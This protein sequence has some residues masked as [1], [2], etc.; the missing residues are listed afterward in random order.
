MNVRTR[1]LVLAALMAL[2]AIGLVMALTQCEGQPAPATGTPT[3]QPGAPSPT[4]TS[5]AA[6]TAPPNST[7]Q[8]ATAPP[9]PIPEDDAPMVEVPAGEFIMG[10]AGEEIPR[11][12]SMRCFG[13]HCG[14]TDYVRDEW[15]QMTVYLDEFE[16]DQ[17]EVIYARYERCVE[18]G[19]CSPS[20][21][22]AP[23][24]DHPVLVKWADA[25]AYCRWV[26][27]RLPTEA[28][29]E[30]AARGIDGRI[31]PWGDEWDA[32]WLQVT[33]DMAYGFKTVSV[34]SHPE[35]ASPYGA[36]DMAGNAPEWVSDLYQVYPSGRFTETS[37]WLGGPYVRRGAYPLSMGT[38]DVPALHYRAADR[39]PGG[40]NDLSGFRCA[41][42]PEPPV[43][44][45]VMG[46]STSW[47]SAD[48]PVLFC[49]ELHEFYEFIFFS[50]C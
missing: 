7:P 35:G 25:D 46:V 8:P 6:A 5:A 36:L 38:A 45:D 32:L 15:P 4:P 26:G 14:Y 24:P 11:W 20:R 18:A 49:H 34:G 9:T 21:E 39:F 17:V 47:G 44:E 22:P 48:S 3:T 29:W 12:E 23:S 13:S 10:T 19:V 50:S 1:I 27:K 31:Y 43:L 40:E 42:G 41:R 37:L 33:F 28:E 30:K 2:G 16:I